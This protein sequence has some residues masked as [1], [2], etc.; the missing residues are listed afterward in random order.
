MPV[1]T[2]PAT[3]RSSRSARPC[4]SLTVARW[5]STGG[6]GYQLPP[7]GG[8]PAGRRRAGSSA[9]MLLRGELRLPRQ[10]GHSGGSGRWLSRHLGRGL[11]APTGRSGRLVLRERSCSGLRRWW[12]GSPGRRTLAQVVERRRRNFFHLLGALRGVAPPLVSEL[13][14]G[15]CP[16]FYPLW[17]A[18]RD[19]VLA[20]LRVEN[21]EAN[22]GWRALPSALRRRGVP[23]GGPAPPARARAALPPGPGPGARGPRGACGAARAQPGPGSTAPARR[24]AER[25]PRGGPFSARGPGLPLR[26][27]PRRLGGANLRGTQRR[28]GQRARGRP[29][30]RLRE[31]GLGL[32][33]SGLA[34]RRGEPRSRASSSPVLAASAPEASTS[35]AGTP[36][37][38]PPAASTPRG[39]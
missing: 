39:R 4:P 1:G 33:S 11:P 29:S 35:W 30:G 13:P 24:G 8:P 3:P 26:S 16:L 7:L 28:L 36:R 34:S 2:R 19:E 14:P 38:R 25:V 9:R 10:G 18:D 5:C 20:R 22:E 6:A 37:V 17:V 21:V 27:A 31:R 12:S 32:V 23:R 15:V